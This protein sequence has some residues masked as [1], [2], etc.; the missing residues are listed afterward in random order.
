MSAADRCP[1][2]V[3]IVLVLASHSVEARLQDRS[4]AATPAERLQVAEL[5]IE[6]VHAVS[7]SDLRA[8]LKTRQSSRL[9]W[10]DRAYFE[11]AV[12]DADLRSI[13]AFY[14]ERGYPHA[15]AEGVVSRGASNEAL[16]QIV[17]REGDPVRA[18]QVFFSGFEVLSTEQL[19]A[20][21]GAAPLQPGNAVAKADVEE[22]VRR[23]VTEL[24]DAGYAN[25]R[26]AALET[27]VAPDRVRIEI[28]AEPGLQAVFG[29]IDIVGNVTVQDPVI[30][31]RLTY[32]PGERFQVT[33]LQESRRRVYQLGL[34]ESV[35]ITVID[36]Q[37]Q[38]S[39]VATRVAV[40]ERDHAQFT[41][42]FGYG[43]EEGVY[44]EAGWRHLD[45]L[46]GGR[47]VSTRGR[48][49][50]L[51]RGGEGTFVQPYLFTPS[52]T[53][54]ARGYV[55]HVDDVT[56]DAFSGGGRAGVSYELG[57]S[58]FAGTYV[59][60]F[61]RAQLPASTLD[62]PRSQA[63]LISLGIDASSATQSGL[64]SA[65]QISAER[66]TTVQSGGDT[67][68]YVVAA[69][70]EQAG[71][72]LPGSF[73][74]VSV[75]GDSRYFHTTGRVTLAGRLQY[76][77]IVPDRQKSDVPFSK[78][79]FLGGSDN[80]RGW[81]RLEV[82]PL[83]AA[84]LPIGGQSFVAASGEVRF[85]AIGPVSGA[86]FVDAGKVWE[87]AWTFAGD[88]HS[89]AGI[90]VRYQS[91]F[92]LLRFDFAHQLTRVDG[93]RIEGEPRDRR[94]RLHFGIGHSF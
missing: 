8:L 71:G 27:V 25:A 44:G 50:W 68:G 58:T 79:F 72:W 91:P 70:L 66:D 89:D 21:E 11:A 64:L 17:V 41:Y 31:R 90:G 77:S 19:R 33:A 9:P 32:L 78:R 81:G 54:T 51:D 59:H 80:L 63:Q 49:S 36:R 7:E 14:A 5:T 13:E 18:L 38:A 57:R 82:S 45:F 6:G 28:R 60:D 62:D 26:V 22:T 83:S 85:P 35:E 1:R 34:F 52:L 65:L 55:W 92:A 43:S 87:D 23:A 4:P 93:V 73:N 12:F 3:L 75:F 61:L 10:R 94:W 69:R 84:G 67:R 48:W 2:S 39:G 42:S 76:G 20:I 47:T 46:G 24:W 29:S 86:L 30:R 56:Y 88:L 16:L 53:L 37:S 40:K 15:R 74:Y